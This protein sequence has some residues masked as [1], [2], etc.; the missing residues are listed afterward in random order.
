MSMRKVITINLNGK[1]YQIED[2][3]YEALRRYLDRAEAQLAGNPDRQEILSDLEQAIGDKC[4]GFLGAHKNV[5]S[6]AE[7]EQVIQQMGPVEDSL[8]ESTAGAAADP[9]AGG[10][11][12]R[13]RR[14]YR[15]AEKKLLAGVCT[16]LAAY[17]G[18]DV[19]LVRILVVALTLCTGVVAFGYLL[20]IFIVPRADTPAEVA[21]AHGLPFSARDVVDRAKKKYAAFRAA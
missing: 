5:V 4:G 19:V 1:A 10:G 2:D 11:A 21:A 16:G 14:L 20:M 17:F 6:A 8:G 13:V 9:A 7:V 15:L 18:V 3:G 12:P